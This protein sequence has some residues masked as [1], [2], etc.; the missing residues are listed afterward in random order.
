MTVARNKTLSR[1]TDDTA[2]ERQRLGV[3]SG[4]P[5]LTR[6]AAPGGDRGVGDDIQGR[7]FPVGA[8]IA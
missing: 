6:G 1:T 5:R 7:D 8:S 3:T 2:E 4:S